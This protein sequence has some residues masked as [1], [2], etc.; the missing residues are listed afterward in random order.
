MAEYPC[1]VIISSDRSGRF[2]Q[3]GRTVEVCIFRLDG[4]SEWT[5]EVID[6]SGNS[7][8]WNQPFATDE[9]A[10]RTFAIAIEREGIE[11]FIATFENKQR[12]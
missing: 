7:T 6:G 2:E 11:P 8:V 3:G 5:L 10:W 1:P 4:E 9:D 12:S